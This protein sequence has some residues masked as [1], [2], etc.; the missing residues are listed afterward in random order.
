[1]VQEG[2][3]SVVI[4]KLEEMHTQL[5]RLIPHSLAERMHLAERELQGENRLVT[6]LFA[7]ISG[8]TPL[9]QSLPTEAVVELRRFLDERLK[10]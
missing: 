7:D 9:S 10:G 4:P 8:F 6:A 2:P 1:L 3:P 5:Q